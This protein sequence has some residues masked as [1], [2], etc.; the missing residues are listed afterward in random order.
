MKVAQNFRRNLL[1]IVKGIIRVMKFENFLLI[2]T[3]F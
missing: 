3:L 2:V 1:Q